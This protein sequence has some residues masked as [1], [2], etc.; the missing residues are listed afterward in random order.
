VRSHDFAREQFARV[1]K[2]TSFNGAIAASYLGGTPA[3]KYAY[4]YGNNVVVDNRQTRRGDMETKL[5]VRSGGK[6]NS[7]PVALKKNNQGYWKV[8]EYSSLFTGVKP[9]V[10]PGDF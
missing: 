7:S 6:D 1:I 9:A 3:N 10:D 2:G 8:F 5:F 4:S